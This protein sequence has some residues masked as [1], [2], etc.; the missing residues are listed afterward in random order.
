VHLYLQKLAAADDLAPSLPDPRLLVI[1]ADLMR[2]RG[3]QQA[4]DAG[5]RWA[6]VGIWSAIAMTWLIVL[7]W[8]LGEIQSLLERFDLVPALP[9]GAMATAVLVAAAGGLM[10]F[11]IFAV[12][13][14]SVLAEL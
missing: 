5:V 3:D 6:G 1:K 12:A 4:E 2:A 9:G 10:A 11:A 14:H 7:T 13:V 8:K